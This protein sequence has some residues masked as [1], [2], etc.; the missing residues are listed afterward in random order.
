METDPVV[1]TR[2]PNRVEY[3]RLCGQCSSTRTLRLED[4]Q[5]VVAVPIPEPIRDIPDH[6]AL[7]SVDRKRGLMLRRLRFPLPEE[8]RNRA[9]T[10]QNDEYHVA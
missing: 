10:R 6:V 8:L 4:D 1:R 7:I 5:T 2:N 3:F 9:R